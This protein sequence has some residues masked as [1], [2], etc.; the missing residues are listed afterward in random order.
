M[1]CTNHPEVFDQVVPCARCGQPFC[2]SCRIELRG[3]SVCVRC[4]REDLLDLRSGRRLDG[5]DLASTGRRFLALFIDNLL[6]GVVFYSVLFAVVMIAGVAGM[7]SGTEAA[8][9]AILGFGCVVIL[10]AFICRV[11]YEG[12]MLQAKSQTVGKMVVGIEVV[13]PS[14]GRIRPGQAWMRAGMRFLLDSVLS[15]VNYLPAFF[16]PDRTCLHDM[17]ATT[18][19]INRESPPVACPLCNKALPEPVSGR[20]RCPECNRPFEAMSFNPPQLVPR[21][22]RL[23]EA[24]PAAANACGRHQEN[25]AVGTCGRCGV[26]LCELCRLECDGMDLCPGCFERLAAA[27]ELPSLRRSRR[28]YPGMVA[29]W[30]LS[31]VLMWPLMPVMG[32]V[33]LV[34]SVLGLRQTRRDGDREPVFRLVVSLVLSVIEMV[35]GIALWIGLVGSFE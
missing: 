33:G 16:T 29:L 19:V 26:F 4:K 1:A 31:G 17:I 34:Y 6:W 22:R 2:P 5:L 35:G 32:I 15:L 28:N 12:W 25:V 13:T 24:G 7:Q 20:V 30:L 10:L 23:S 11:V 27:E 8:G 3:R 14:G 9:M 21:A 18:R